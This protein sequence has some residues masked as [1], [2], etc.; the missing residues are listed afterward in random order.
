[1]IKASQILQIIESEKKFWTSIYKSDE[2]HWIDKKPSNLS[3]KVVRKYGNLGRILEIGCAAGVDTFY[4]A[5]HCDSIVGIDIVPDA[6]KIAS[7]HLA[8]STKTLQKKIIFE[9]GDAEKLNYSDASFD[10]VYSLSVLHSTNVEKS[11]P[12]VRRVLNDEGRAVLYVY[13]GK[14]KEEVDKEKFL[15]TCKEYFTIE[16][17][18]EIDIKKDAGDDTHHAL[19]VWLEVI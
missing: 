6:I 18:E 16:K 5:E 7:D 9:V 4:L 17:Q 14:G 2:A 11:I 1:M 12:E 13:T 15:S 19:I 3:K 8:E 10:F